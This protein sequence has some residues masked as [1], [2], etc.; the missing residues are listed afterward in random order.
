MGRKTRLTPERQA[1]ICQ[2][3][4]AGAH[5]NTAARFGGITYQTFAV[6]MAKGDTPGREPYSSFR[7]AVLRAE[8]EAEV[9]MVAAWQSHGI[10]TRENPGDWRALRDLLA[11][12]H[13]DRWM[14]RE[15]RE[16]SGPAGSPVQVVV[17]ARHA[18]L[19]RLDVMQGRLNPVVV[20]ELAE[21]EEA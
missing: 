19:E 11:R 15:G 2:A 7:E 18:L 16:I 12:R 21:A 6:W 13:P 10:G 4:T 14:P 1:R 9:R 5:L 3:I 20:A 17:D 8:V